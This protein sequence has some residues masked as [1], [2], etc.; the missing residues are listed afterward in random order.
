MSASIWRI[1]MK[2]ITFLACEYSEIG[3]KDYYSFYI[4]RSMSPRFC[5]VSIWMGWRQ[6]GVSSLM[7]SMVATRP[8]IAFP[9]GVVS[10]YHSHWKRHYRES[11]K[12]QWKVLRDTSDAQ[13][14]LCICIG[15]QKASV[16]RFMDAAYHADCRK[17]TSGYVFTFTGGTISWISRLQKCVALPTTETEHVAGIEA[18]KEALWI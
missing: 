9:M 3:Q 13:K 18:H 12:K 4:N 2:Q 11:I 5:S 10:R 7:Y 6:L 17:F 14:D 15:K 1:I 16:I 8:G